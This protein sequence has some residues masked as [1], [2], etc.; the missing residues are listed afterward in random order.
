MDLNASSVTTDMV[1]WKLLSCSLSTSL[2]KGLISPGSID[3]TTLSDVFGAVLLDTIRVA[4][5]VHK[6]PPTRNGIP[7]RL[8]S[9]DDFPADWFPTI[10]SYILSVWQKRWSRER[11]CGM[12]RSWPAPQLRRLLMAS[13]SCLLSSLLKGSSFNSGWDEVKL[14]SE[15]VVSDSR[16]W[17][18]DSIESELELELELSL[19][20]VNIWGNCMNKGNLMIIVDKK[21]IWQW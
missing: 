2:L 8:L 21:W 1:C 9:K 15:W 3:T 4:K 6:P 10:T 20:V 13:K 5:R 16:S 11:T 18:S 7:V 12:S 17:T 14:S 19:L